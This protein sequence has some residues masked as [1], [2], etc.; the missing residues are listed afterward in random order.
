[1]YF[2]NHFNNTTNNHI[3]YVIY[4]STTLYK[5]KESVKLTKL[6]NEVI[7][8]TTVTC[9]LPVKSRVC[10]DV[11]TASFQLQLTGPV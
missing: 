8:L 7:F 11:A 10:V 6:T 2:N 5:K 4:I 9:D 3:T 1:M